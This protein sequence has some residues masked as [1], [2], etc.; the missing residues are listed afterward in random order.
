MSNKTLTMTDKLYEYLIRHSLREPELLQR[1]REETAKDPLANMQIAPEQ[2]QFM[3]LL[4]QLIGAKKTIEIG[5][6]TGY[7]SLGMSLL[8]TG[9]QWACGCV[10]IVNRNAHNFRAAVYVVCELVDGLMRR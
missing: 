10:F 8:L 7:S 2:G 6:F 5:V 1:L 9:K 4:I 3:A